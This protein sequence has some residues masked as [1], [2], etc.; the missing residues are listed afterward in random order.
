[1]TGV[2]PK[3][4]ELSWLGSLNP[5][6]GRQVPS[7]DAL[8]LVAAPVAGV[9]GGDVPAVCKADIGAAGCTGAERSGLA[10]SNRPTTAALRMPAIQA[11]NAFPHSWTIWAR[12]SWVFR[13]FMPL[14]VSA[15]DRSILLRDFRERPGGLTWGLR[16]AQIL[17]SRL[18]LKDTGAAS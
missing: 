18:G 5:R 12:S 9:V 6:V 17:A 3:R 11:P 15:R 4:S 1:M 8:V 16:M 13:F 7:L 2:P 14:T 10:V